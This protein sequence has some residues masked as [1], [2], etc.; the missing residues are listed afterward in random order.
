VLTIAR[1]PKAL[2]EQFQST[3]ARTDL[4]LGLVASDATLSRPIA[5]RH[6]FIFYVGHLPAFA[7]NHICRGVLGVPSFQPYFDEVFDRGIDPD[8][9]DPTRVHAHPEVPTRWPELRD[10]L[11]YRD[12]VRHAVLTALPDVEA[13]ASTDPMAR[14]GRVCAMALEHEQ[15]HQE[16]LLYMVQQLPPEQIVRPSRPFDY[17]FGDRRRSRIVEVPGGPAT[18]GA[19]FDGLDFGW[20]NEFPAL[21]V[22]V[23][24]FVIDSLPITNRQF[25]SFLQAGGYDRADFWADEDWQWRQ[26]RP[27][28]HP[29]CWRERA[30]A[31]FYRTLFEWIPFAQ[32]WD[33]PVY[34]S[35]AEARAYAR[36][37]GGRLLTE[38]EFHRAAYGTV[39]GGERSYPW[40]DEPP[41]VRHGNVDFVRWTPDPVG[42]HPEGASAFGV[43]EL[44][45]NGWEWTVTPFA[46]LP[47]FSA[48]IARYP[49][50]SAD[51]FDDKHF[52]LKGGSWATAA[53]LTRP[54]FRN[55]YQARY[56]YPFAKFR[57]VRN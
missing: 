41:T 9:E 42:S 45:G 2:A 8:V 10:V 7:W 22:E 30:G 53:P 51:F 27:Q 23:P 55:W 35:L 13:H 26:R 52:V 43:H 36:W 11:A 40:G 31:W 25:F 29:T 38:P 17:P 1:T 50:Y 28:A 48:Y 44:I 34:V 24:P 32:V 14:H 16:T 54:T 39:D 19:D 37:S 33:W 21:T 18:L 46:P 56:P 20:D 4:L 3:W 15:M 57:C 47:G 12:R 6:P 5:L 49:G